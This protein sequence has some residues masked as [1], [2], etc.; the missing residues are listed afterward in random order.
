MLKNWK[1]VANKV[2][3]TRSKLD[4]LY[5]MW[6]CHDLLPFRTGESKYFQNFIAALKPITSFH[7]ELKSF[8]AWF[9]NLQINSR[10]TCRDSSTTGCYRRCVDNWCLDIQIL[11][12]LWGSYCPFHSQE[13]YFQIGYVR[14]KKTWQPNSGWACATNWKNGQQTPRANGT[15]NKINFP[16]CGSNE[17][18]LSKTLSQLVWMYSSYH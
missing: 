1:R 14:Y 9:Q 18:H 3:V 11:W 10:K 8:S 6:L 12:Q 13:F 7:Q 5:V 17:G 4:R 16:Q 2:N 15:S